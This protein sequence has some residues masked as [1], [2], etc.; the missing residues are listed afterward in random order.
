MTYATQAAQYREMQVMTASPEQLVV[1]LYDHLLVCLRR[2]RLAIETA[3]VEMRIDLLD[4]SRRVVAE[5]L[6]TLNREKGGAIA[7]D[8]VSLY[9]FLLTELT[10]IGRTPSPQRLDRVTGIATELRD[11]FAVAAGEQVEVG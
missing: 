9:A 10:D 8:L 3:N 1:I 11:A 6:V 4:K 7:K 2:A 5:L